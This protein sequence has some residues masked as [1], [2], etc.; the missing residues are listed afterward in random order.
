MEKLKKVIEQYGR[1]AELTVF[2]ERIEAHLELD[3][4]HSLENAKAL[5]EAICK[6]ICE[7]K[8][9]E[10]GAKPSVNNV[11]RSAFIA[12]GFTSTEMVNQIS[13]ALATIG[14][15]VGVLRNEIGLTSHGKTLDE[16]KVR[17]DGVDLLTRE[18]L[19]DSIEIVASFLIRTFENENPR[20]PQKSE[21]S[22]LDYF[23]AV[24]F[25]E[26]WDDVFG[27]F[28]MGNYSYAASEILFHVDNQAYVNEYKGFMSEETSEETVEE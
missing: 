1:W 12:L 13:S 5:L 17:N 23:E 4:S 11:L 27:E 16:I 24:E 21:E 26:Y 19:V 15:Q 3:F 20:V 10:L 25:N 7:C 6:E 22:S 8:N 14:Q 18:F 9:F 28:S 2:I